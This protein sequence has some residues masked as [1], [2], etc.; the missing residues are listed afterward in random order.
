MVLPHTIHSVCVHVIT[1]ELKIKTSGLAGQTENILIRH[2]YT[3]H[4]KILG[5]HCRKLHGIWP[6]A[7]CYF[8]PCYCAWYMTCMI[9]QVSQPPPPPPPCMKPCTVCVHMCY[10]AWYMTCV[11]SQVSQPPPPP[12]MKPCTVCVHMCYCAWYMTCVHPRPCRLALPSPS[13]RGTPSRRTCGRRGT[14]SS[15]GAR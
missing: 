11:I 3:K 13:S 1:A 15:S 14:G 2:L 10:C 8:Q 5:G 7:S 6:R 4:D 9:S 12:R